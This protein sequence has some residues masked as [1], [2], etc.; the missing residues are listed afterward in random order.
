M[1]AKKKILISHLHPEGCKSEF[2]GVRGEPALRKAIKY[3][4]PDLFLHA[5]IHE[6][7]GLE[8]KIGKTRVINIGRR[9]KIL[10][11]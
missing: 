6:G 10:E 4:E 2:S 3:F 9:G 8:E 1:K 5:H 7:E 11:I